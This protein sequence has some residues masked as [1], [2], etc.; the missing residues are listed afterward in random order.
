MSKLRLLRAVFSLIAVGAMGL[1]PA[2]A[3]ADG[4]SSTAWPIAPAATVSA[5]N[6]DNTTIV[7]LG[8]PRRIAQTQPM[9]PPKH[10]PLW[11]EGLD[12]T[13]DFSMA[14]PFGNTGAPKTYGLSG[15]MDGIF[16]YTWGDS[17]RLAIGWYDLQEYPLGFD[18]GIV[19]LYLQGS[20]VPIGTTP[21]SPTIPAGCVNLNTPPV[22]NTAIQNHIL[23]AHYDQV[24][25]TKLG[26]Q[27]FPLILSPTFTQRWGTVGGGTDLLPVEIDGFPYTLHYRTGSF[28]AIGL[29]FPVPLLTQPRHG[30]ITTYTVGPQWLM[31]MQGANVDNHAQLV[32]ILHTVWHP[33]PRIQI[34][35]QPSLYPNELATDKWP[36]HYF[37]MIY[38][39]AYSFGSDQ[40]DPW[41]RPLTQH[42]IPFVQATVSMGGAINIAPYGITALYCQQL[43]CTS[44]SQIY[45]SL[46]GNHAAQFQL[47]LGVGRPSVIPL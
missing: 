30:L 6:N 38:S 45:P 4:N 21:C 29:T 10:I 28:G 47:K 16:R 7:P 24:F 33:T 31:T 1:S 44:P 34:D 35:L 36:Q 25:W 14:R 11:R 20:A 42:L 2:T 32:Q 22:T 26:G 9:T 8:A 17:R 37:T 23:I 18:T 12:Y 19:P 46:G 43:P 5:Q 27:D 15:G 39:A 41:G 13:I 3:R 40:R